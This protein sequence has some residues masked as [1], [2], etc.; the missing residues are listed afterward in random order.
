MQPVHGRNGGPGRGA[1]GGGPAECLSSVGMKGH[2]VSGSLGERVSVRWFHAPWRICGPPIPQQRL[3]ASIAPW[4]LLSTPSSRG[5]W[6]AS[7]PDVLADPPP[8]WGTS[9]PRGHP[10]QRVVPVLEDAGRTAAGLRRQTC[11][12][13]RSAGTGSAGR[14]RGPRGQAGQ[15]SSGAAGA[16]SLTRRESRFLFVLCFCEATLFTVVW[17]GAAPTI[18]LRRVPSGAAP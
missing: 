2:R 9:L 5:G 18:R 3:L 13:A 6:W 8:G 10:R 12:R 16:I 7:G 11:R 1:W 4:E 15:C 17:G 14:L